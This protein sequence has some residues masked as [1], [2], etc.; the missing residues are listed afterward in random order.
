[1]YAAAVTCLKVVFSGDK[2]HGLCD[3]PHRP[4][5][6]ILLHPRLPPCPQP[7]EGVQTTDTQA[8]F[9]REMAAV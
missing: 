3:S 8:S 1:M 4:H 5:I 9:F 2:P 7:R 6:R